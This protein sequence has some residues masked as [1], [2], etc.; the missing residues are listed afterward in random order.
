MLSEV[1]GADLRNWAR[2]QDKQ[3]ARQALV[4]LGKVLGLLEKYHA[5]VIGRV[6][7]KT[8]GQAL[9]PAPTYSYAIQDVAKHF[10]HLLAKSETHGLMV[11]DSRAYSQDIGV[12]H[13]VFTQKHQAGGDSYP[14]LIDT[15]VFGRSSNHVGLQL[16]DCVAAG[17]VFPMAVAVYQSTWLSTRPTRHREGFEKIRK[18]HAGTLKGLR[19]MYKDGSGKAAGGNRCERPGGQKAQ[20]SSLQLVPICRSAWRLLFGVLAHLHKELQGLIG[21]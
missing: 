10:Q 9:D 19:Y 17:L 18:T 2:D 6:W 20:W 12:S 1:K 13:S 21:L 16:A 14:A 15:T 5:E 4:F 11:C 3:K 8:P 7:V